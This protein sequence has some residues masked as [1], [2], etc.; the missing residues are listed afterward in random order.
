MNEPAP[1][2]SIAEATDADAAAYADFFWHAWKEAGPEAPGFIGASDQ[3]IA[4]VTRPEAFRERIGGPDRRMYLAR[5][6]T[7]VVGF[8]ATSL[9]DSRS[10]ELVGIIVLESMT[11][12]GIGLRLA[13]A[14]IATVGRDGCS[15]IIVKTETTNKRARGF[16]ERCG[17]STT[18]VT[19]EDVDGVPIDVWVLRRDTVPGS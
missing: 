13:E 2:I 18:G 17:F 10:A 8:A 1:A 5:E 12:R 4:E 3:V 7:R 15:T 16:Y 19:T 14:A 11:G 6:G 9:H